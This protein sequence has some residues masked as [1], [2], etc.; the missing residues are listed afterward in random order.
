MVRFCMTI[1]HGEWKRGDPTSR[2]ERTLDY[3][4][5]ADAAG[6][7]SIWLNEDPDG[8]D[9]FAV[10]GAMAR[11]TTHVRLGCGV[12]NVYHRNPN[13]IAA[14]VSTLDQLSGG[15]AFLGIGRGQPEVYEYAFGLD[16]SEPLQRMERA[17][18]QL[19]QWWSPPFAAPAGGSAAADWKRAIGPR[20]QP[21]IY[22]AAV[23]P[24]A[25]DLAG[26]VADGVLFNEMA[27]PEYI[28]WAVSRVRRAA[29]ANDRDATSV[30]FFVN[31]A[32][33]VTDDRLPVLERKKAFIAQVHALPG[34]D[35]LLTTG[36]WDVQGIMATV[37]RVMRT[38]E[39][40]SRGGMFAGMREVGDLAAAKA[41]IPTELVDHA[42]A[43]GSLP[44]V[45][46]KLERFVACGATHLFIDRRGLPNDVRQVRGLIAQLEI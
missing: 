9:A 4:R 26:R 27:T 45:R 44:V 14:S 10:L 18:D 30:L 41:A 25:L 37:R 32:V 35:R 21:P 12:T 11:E 3:A 31:P 6:F 17:I 15:R 20:G 36:Q 33:T 22:I 38:D 34:M 46:A 40:L 23:G 5:L 1:D 42:S 8:W 19:R 28:E 16:A 43:I 24:R 2:V 13:L 7:D 39:V 29:I